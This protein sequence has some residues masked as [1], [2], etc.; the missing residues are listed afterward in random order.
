M[1]MIND[2]KQGKVL[3]TLFRTCLKTSGGNLEKIIDVIHK[4]EE[5]VCRD[6]NEM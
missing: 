6:S 4:L 2:G 3:N 1:N 5:Q